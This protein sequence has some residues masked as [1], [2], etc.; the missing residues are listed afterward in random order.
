MNLIKALTRQQKLV[1]GDVGVE[2]E[3]EGK[4]LFEVVNPFWKTVDDGSLRGTFPE[5]RAEFVLKS[6]LPHTKA[7]EAITKLFDEL[8]KG[9]ALFNFSFRTS[10]HVHVNITDMNSDELSA[11]IYAYYL[12]E[13]PLINYCGKSRR[14]NRFCLRLFDAEGMLQIINS[15]IKDHFSGI[16]FVAED[17]VRYAALNMAAIYKYGSVEFR[18]MRGTSEV[19]VLHKWVDMLMSLKKFSLGKNPMDVKNLY[20]E[21]GSIGFLNLVMGELSSHLMYKDIEKDMAMSRSLSLDIPYT[22]ESYCKPVSNRDISLDKGV[23]MGKQ[24]IIA[25][26]GRDKELLFDEL[27]KMDN[28]EF[29]NI[30]NEP[31]NVQL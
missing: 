27:V 12:L 26:V 23:P 21:N 28:N 24:F 8:T 9:A 22:W 11:L 30:L 10:T 17:S 18:G 13:E 20:E 31:M 14:A 19:D 5:S 29:I 15:Q 3:V 7:K 2:V 1:K 4:N 16:S 6:P 25:G